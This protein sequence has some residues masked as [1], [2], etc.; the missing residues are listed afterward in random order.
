METCTF[1]KHSEMV[2]D[3]TTTH[4]KWLGSHEPH[5]RQTHPRSCP[6]AKMI[7]RAV[8]FA[9]QTGWSPYGSGFQNFKSK[10]KFWCTIEW[11]L[12]IIANTLKQTRWYDGNI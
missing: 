5:I 6:L 9:S 7:S 1:S 3:Y 4:A 12:I 10:L 8:G 11:E 2:K